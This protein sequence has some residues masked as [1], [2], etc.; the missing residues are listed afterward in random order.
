MQS[1]IEDIA[2][3][4]AGMNMTATAAWQMQRLIESGKIYENALEE[5]ARLTG[6]SEVALKTAF[7]RAGVKAMRFDDGIYKAVGLNPLPLNLSPA[8]V[9]V[10]AAGLRKT[11]G[12]MSNLT[13]TT[14]LSGQNAFIEAADLAYLQVSSGAMD[15][16]SAIRAAV[17]DMAA[18][19]LSVINF[20][21]RRDQ[22]DVAM[23]RTLLTG[24]NQTVGN[25]TW[26]RADEMGVDLVQT[27]AHIGAR[28][29]HQLWQGKIFS[30]SGQHPQYPDFVTETGYG[31]GPGLGGWNCR[32]SFFP[33]FEAISES[34]YRQAE[35]EGY[36]DKT[37]TYNGEE[38]S[39]YEATQKQREIERK[40][41]DWKRQEGAL[42]AAGLDTT[43]ETAKVKAWQAQMRDFTRQT[44]LMRQRERERITGVAD[45]KD[46]AARKTIGFSFL[47]GEQTLATTAEARRMGDSMNGWEKH[48]RIFRKDYLDKFKVRDDIERTIGF[49]GG[50]EPSFNA[51]VLGM[52]E[53]VIEMSKAWGKNYNQQAVALLFPN[54][55]GTGGKLIWDFGRELSNQ[56]WD[57]FFLSLDKINKTLGEKY[58]DYFG[59]TVKGLQK[60]EYW[61]R[62]IQ[63]GNNA[64][65][66]IRLA[67]EKLNLKPNYSIW[68]GFE[69]ILLEAGKDY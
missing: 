49:W 53:N 55:N 3:R 65:E 44:G 56:E 50:P 30:R 13:M 66:V 22:L 35:L 28:P 4:L 39:F 27:S 18:N 26:T 14:A 59:V 33:F 48:E 51:H 17:K 32:H 52:R 36:A 62:N 15:Y 63:Q 23:R 9:E 54:A 11:G 20:S 24:I 68:R 12:V 38:I 29:T 46:I 34:A 47:S 21:G 10:L 61:Y 19:G 25:L 43:G 31:T 37:V 41:R 57:H 45:V 1:V 7:E 67:I 60:V 58:N 2:R 40:I 64:R 6:Q 5:I 42:K 69:F 16:N 8:M